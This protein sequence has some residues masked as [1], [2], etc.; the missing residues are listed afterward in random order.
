METPNLVLPVSLLLLARAEGL[1]AGLISI[2][3]ASDNFPDAVSL[4]PQLYNQWRLLRSVQVKLEETRRRLMAATHNLCLG[5][6]DD[7][8]DSFG[9]PPRF[10]ETAIG[11]YRNTLLRLPPT[12]LGEVLALCSLSHAILHCAG[13]RIRYGFLDLEIWRNAVNHDHRQAFHD[14]ISA[15]CL[16]PHLTSQAFCFLPTSVGIS[17]LLPPSYREEPSSISTSQGE[18]LANDALSSGLDLDHTVYDFL[19]SNSLL[20]GQPVDCSQIISE[21]IQLTDTPAP[22][23]QDLQGSP[24]MSNLTHF[25]EDCG[26]LTLVLSSPSSRGATIHQSTRF[27]V[28][29]CVDPFYIECLRNS[30]S[31]EDSSVQAIVSIIDRFS[32][33]GYLHSANEARDYMLLLAKVH[34][35]VAHSPDIRLDLR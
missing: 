32:N 7:S 5:G 28:E 27:G 14:L 34:P 18:D 13:N 3:T 30:P 23:L 21:N 12:T 33:L 17:H 1:L 15:A 10:S 4:S 2:A 25:L 11:S 20:T 6:L 8:L 26:E 31:F 22:D 29:R 16:E 24:I 9:D 35:L 19:A